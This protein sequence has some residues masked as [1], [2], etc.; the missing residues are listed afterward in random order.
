M[1]KRT[2]RRHGNNNSTA[3][4]RRRQERPYRRWVFFFVRDGEILR[5]I[6]EGLKAAL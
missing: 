2:R 3:E 1:S 6:A 4:R 5:R